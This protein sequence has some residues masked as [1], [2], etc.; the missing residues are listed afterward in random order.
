MREREREN[1][2]DVE[3]QCICMYVCERERERERENGAE[4]QG[5]RFN[6]CVRGSPKK[7]QHFTRTCMSERGPFS[8]DS[9]S[10]SSHAYSCV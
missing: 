5:V 2:K 3:E 4:G 1:K 6:F 9:L 7:G 8:W 10:H